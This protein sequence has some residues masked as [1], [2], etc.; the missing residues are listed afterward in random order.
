MAT[1]LSCRLWNKI[2]RE[3]F[4]PG[5]TLCMDSRRRRLPQGECRQGPAKPDS[6]G[7]RDGQRT[8]WAEGGNWRVTGVRRLLAC[9]R[10]GAVGVRTPVPGFTLARHGAFC[11]F[12]HLWASASGLVAG[13]GGRGELWDPLR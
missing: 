7:C 1:P 2:N 9:S 6:F 12:H 5:S 4:V 10:G 3:D 8:R 13:D 11:K